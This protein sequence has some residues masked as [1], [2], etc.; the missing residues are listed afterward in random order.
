MGSCCTAQAAHNPRPAKPLV[1]MCSYGNHFSNFADIGDTVVL[2]VDFGD[3]FK[4]V[5]RRNLDHS[6]RGATAGPVWPDRRDDRPDVEE[7]YEVG[8]KMRVIS[9]KFS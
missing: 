2:F 3:Q 9:I 8:C 6:L 5:P 7:Q 1:R 4:P